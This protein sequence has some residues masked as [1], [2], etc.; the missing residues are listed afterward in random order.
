MSYVVVP[1]LSV[2]PC[3]HTSIILLG[4][5][6]Y[7]TGYGQVPRPR[8]NTVFYRQA[9]RVRIPLCLPYPSLT[10][11]FRS[12]LVGF[13]GVIPIFRLKVIPISHSHF[14]SGL[15]PPLLLEAPKRAVKLYVH[16]DP[17]EA[18]YLRIHVLLKRG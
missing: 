7:A 3:S 18:R 14:P 15:V 6:S 1:S 5:N 4:E 16:S 12:V 17:K 11:S 13:I 9:R 8:R 10:T 2:S